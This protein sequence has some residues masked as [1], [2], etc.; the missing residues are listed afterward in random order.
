MKLYLETLKYAVSKATLQV[1][2]CVD[3]SVCSGEYTTRLRWIEP[4]EAVD[5]SVN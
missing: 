2:W 1:W 5:F 4:L 3:C